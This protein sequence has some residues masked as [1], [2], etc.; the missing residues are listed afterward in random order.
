V[1]A[2]SLA[3]VP[4]LHDVMGLQECT[5]SF[6]SNSS[7]K[8]AGIYIRCMTFSIMVSILSSWH[9]CDATNGGSSITAMNACPA[10]ARRHESAAEHHQHQQHQYQHS[11]H[12]TSLGDEHQQQHPE[13][14]VLDASGSEASLNEVPRTCSSNNS[15]KVGI[16]RC[17]KFS[18]I[19]CF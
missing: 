14:T 10:P 16:I 18:I 15:T 17:M 4:N 2:A 19:V 1:A 7:S 5:N 6:S 8:K 13:V 3:L 11:G 12:H 9:Y